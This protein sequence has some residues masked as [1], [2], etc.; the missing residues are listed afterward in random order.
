MDGKS[1]ERISGKSPKNVPKSS[2]S[3]AKMAKEKGQSESGGALKILFSNYIFDV[4][5]KDHLD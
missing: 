4:K 5:Q 2:S 3:A 1:P